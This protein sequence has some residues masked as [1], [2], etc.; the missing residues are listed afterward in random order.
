MDKHSSF[1]TVTVNID[2]VLLLLISGPKPSADTLHTEQGRLIMNKRLLAQSV[3]M[4]ARVF[5]TEGQIFMG[6]GAC[7]H[8][9][10]KECLFKNFNLSELS[11]Y[12]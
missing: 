11:I 8:V 6:L 12:P 3:R 9:A 1:T 4:T 7:V 10:G 2:S 5:S